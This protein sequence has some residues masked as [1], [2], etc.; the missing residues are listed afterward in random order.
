MTQGQGRPLIEFLGLP[1]NCP[2]PRIT[3]VLVC[4]YRTVSVE[5]FESVINLLTRGNWRY[6]LRSGDAWIG[7]ARSV[8]ASQWY[9]ETS[10]EVFVMVDAD[11][12]FK[13][14]DLQRLSDQ[15]GRGQEIVCADYPVHN[16]EYLAGVDLP[17]RR[18]GNSTLVELRYAP[19]GCMAVHRIVL[20][21]LVDVLPLCHASLPIAYWPFFIPFMAGDPMTGDNV[22]LSEDFAFSDRARAAGFHL[23]RDA[24]VRVG[25]LSEFV[26]TEDNMAAMHRAAGQTWATA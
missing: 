13:P 11:I 25:H 19:N 14:G 23:W 26:L 16:G 2:S 17:Y 12:I 20:D 5:T 10:D 1:D 18:H 24:S 4:A 8:I 21:A 22:P 6:A 7:R 3:S 15:C 9:R